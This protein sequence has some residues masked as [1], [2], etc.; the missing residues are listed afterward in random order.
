MYLYN[1]V[2][3]MDS[4]RRVRGRAEADVGELVVAAERR[5]HVEP[6]RLAGLPQRHR[7]QGRRLQDHRVRH[8][9]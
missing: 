6:Q 2:A 5:H 9:L 7:V 8:V 3:N 1:L 4:A